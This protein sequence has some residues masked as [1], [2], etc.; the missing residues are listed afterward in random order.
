MPD[1]GR[2]EG[3]VAS[4]RFAIVV[5]ELHFN[6]HDYMIWNAYGTVQPVFVLRVDGVPVVSVYERK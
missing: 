5:H 3:G 1:S 4:S 2:E 6:R